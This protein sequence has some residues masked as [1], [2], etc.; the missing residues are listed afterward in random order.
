[1]LVKILLRNP[2]IIQYEVLTQ[3]LTSYI[4]TYFIPAIQSK[5][6]IRTYKNNKRTLMLWLNEG[7]NAS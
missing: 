6:K 2:H 7:H 5:H 3:H 1:M 4:H